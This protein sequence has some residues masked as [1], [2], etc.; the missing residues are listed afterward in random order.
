MR[1]SIREVAR[2]RDCQLDHLG[3][4]AHDVCQVG[5]VAR[6]ETRQS[7]DCRSDG[8]RA[9]TNSRTP[10]AQDGATEPCVDALGFLLYGLAHM[11][12][13]FRVPPEAR[14]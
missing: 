1:R 7:V 3:A 9:S 5:R 10:A 14:R 8:L 2:D 13:E 4:T 11:S 12:H 6:Q